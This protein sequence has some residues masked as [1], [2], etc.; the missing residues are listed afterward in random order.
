MHVDTGS[1]TWK[2]NLM[3]ILKQQVERVMGKKY[4]VVV[5]IATN[6]NWFL[7]FTVQR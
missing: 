1:R 5:M 4:N 6:I 7:L 2:R 3:T